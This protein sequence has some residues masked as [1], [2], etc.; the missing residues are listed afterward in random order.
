MLQISRREDLERLV[1]DGVR[2]SLSLDYKQSSALSKEDR[3]KDELCKDVTAFANSA[4]GQL[5]FGIEEDKHV[6]VRVDEGAAQGITKEWI[7]QVIDSRV[8]PR[9]EGLII[10]PIQLANGLGFVVTIPQASSRAP[11]QAPDKR[12]YKRQNFQSVAMEDYEVR[13]VLRRATTPELRVDLSFSGE[14]SEAISLASG[15]EFSEPFFLQCVVLNRA[16]TPAHYAIVDILVDHDLD[17]PFARDPFVRAGVVDQPPEPK[18]WLFRRTI[19]APPGVPIFKEGVDGS[20]LG[21]IALRL[22]SKF[23][24]SDPFYVRTQIGAPGFMKSEEWRIQPRSGMLQIY[25]HK[26]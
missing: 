8:Q 22:P 12:Y 21:L 9:I 7:E 24:R 16:A 1:K 5:I 26:S 6:P 4:G 13:D 23:I 18:C 17:N 3:K 10:H 25:R 15:Q 19:S 14:S 20:H 11:H 2:E